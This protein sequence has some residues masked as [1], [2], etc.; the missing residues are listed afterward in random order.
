MNARE[1]ARK[2][3]RQVAFADDEDELR[4]AAGR[5]IA[6][7]EPERGAGAA[8]A[9]ATLGDQDG[10]PEDIVDSDIDAALAALAEQED[11]TRQRGSGPIPYTYGDESDERAAT[12]RSAG[13]H[14]PSRTVKSKFDLDRGGAPASSALPSAYRFRS[15][16]PGQAEARD[17]LQRYDKSAKVKKAWGRTVSDSSFSVSPTVGGETLALSAEIGR[18][19]LKQTAGEAV[20]N[21]T[22]TGT[23]T[24]DLLP[25]VRDATLERLEAMK[26][27]D[28]EEVKELWKAAIS[29][30]RQ[31]L[32]LSEKEAKY[33]F[34]TFLQR[35]KKLGFNPLTATP[36]AAL[37]ALWEK[38]PRDVKLALRPVFGA[39]DATGVTP[40]FKTIL[41]SYATD[42]AATFIIR[43]ADVL[44][45]L[46][47]DLIAISGIPGAPLLSQ[48]VL[49]NPLAFR[50]VLWTVFHHNKKT[51][52]NKAMPPWLRWVFS[53]LN[54]AMAIAVGAMPV[55]GAT[56]YQAYFDST[57]PDT[58][59]LLESFFGSQRGPAPQALSTQ[60]T[61]LVNRV[62]EGFQR[63]LGKAAPVP[64]LPMAQPS[65][66]GLAPRN[67]SGLA[68][69]F[70]LEK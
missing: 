9:A 39:L 31:S 46:I 57:L 23:Q 21:M 52:T 41:D 10:W 32:N 56:V 25:R 3:K 8:G 33:T 68:A 12:E 50:A 62:S 47:S 51:V 35:Y 36:L 14:A 22:T 69:F 20:W 43:R 18:P 2:R 70:G 38:T 53:T 49:T 24:P 54:L 37:D 44:V 59:G 42:K 45:P 17:M 58:P 66:T 30:L 65:Y 7:L 6:R 5:V 60:F 27:A 63:L 1:R 4:T 40:L 26:P 13:Y 28:Q 55:A 29:Q 15:D 48:A 16:M 61:S 19:R 64:S 34:Y 67:S 11:W